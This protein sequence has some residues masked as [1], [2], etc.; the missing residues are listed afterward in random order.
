MRSKVSALAVL[1]KGHRIDQVQVW[2]NQ[3]L[4]TLKTMLK[5]NESRV[6]LW[7]QAW[8]A[9]QGADLVQRAWEVMGESTRGEN[10]RTRKFACHPVP[11]RI[12]EAH[13]SASGA[14]MEAP[15]SSKQKSS[16]ILWRNSTNKCPPDC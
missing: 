12:L 9:M 16:K 8:E 6:P 14:R 11:R 7:R 15:T 10:S 2:A 1:V 4:A 3:T 5:S 13:N